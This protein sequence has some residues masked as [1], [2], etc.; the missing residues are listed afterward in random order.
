MTL[1]ELVEKRR[2]LIRQIQKLEAIDRTYEDTKFD[3]NTVV[4]DSLG[5]ATTL[6]L[7]FL[8][9]SLYGLQLVTDQD[10][11]KSRPAKIALGVPCILLGTALTVPIVAPFAA[12]SAAAEGIRISHAAIN[13]KRIAKIPERIRQ[14]K[15]EKH[16][17]EE[18]IKIAIKNK[19]GR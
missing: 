2:K 14:L 10:K 4:D 1:T 19:Q 6:T 18:E 13:N 11:E 5:I 9:V 16:A 12:I 3:Y 17:V 15:R 7:P 8:T